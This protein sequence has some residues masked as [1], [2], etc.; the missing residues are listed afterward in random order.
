MKTFASL[1]LA[2]F[3]SASCDDTSTENQDNIPAKVNEV[4]N[5]AINGQQWRITHFTN[6]N[7]DRTSVFA[8]Y[9]FEFD[10]HNLL[11][12]TNGSENLSGTWSVSNTPSDDQMK[13]EF[14]NI[15]FTISFTNPTQF[16]ALTGDWEILSITESRI[17]LRDANNGSQNNMIRFERI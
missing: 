16:E 14:D 12:S 15:G 11:T 6:S 2:L 9:I 17:E 7:V 4:E 5:R 3:L 1:L 10:S 8:G 13:T